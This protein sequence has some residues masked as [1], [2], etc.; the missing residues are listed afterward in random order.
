MPIKLN[1]K[2]KQNDAVSQYQLAFDKERITIGREKDSDL[3]IPSDAISRKHAVIFFE[4]GAWFIEDLNSKHGTLVNEQALIPQKI[5]ELRNEDR[6]RMATATISVEII[7]NQLGSF[8]KEETAII[9][10]KM[11]Q[12]LLSS[13]KQTIAHCSLLF[14]NGKQEGKRISIPD[15]VHQLVMGRDSVCDII[16]D[17]ASVSKHHAKIVRD[18]TGLSIESLDGNNKILINGTPVENTVLLSDLDE[19][20]IGSIQLK[21]CNTNDNAALNS[22]VDLEQQKNKSRDKLLYNPTPQS[23]IAAFKL[24]EITQKENNFSSALAPEHIIGN[25]EYCM[26]AVGAF[27]ALGLAAAFV[28]LFTP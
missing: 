28:Y 4:Q 20:V 5:L 9:A 11:V 16:I 12:E 3:R 17:D 22:Q 26:L 15:D 10:R 24:N 19:I 14:C 13:D 25:A 1:I 21:Y 8:V 18:W 6:I 7:R 23:N 27:V 2:V